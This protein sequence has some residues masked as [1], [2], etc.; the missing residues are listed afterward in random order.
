MIYSFIWGNPRIWDQ[1]TVY[2]ITFSNKGVTVQSK[3]Y[4]ENR[5]NVVNPLLRG[6]PYVKTT[7]PTN[8]QNQWNSGVNHY[9]TIAGYLKFSLDMSGESGNFQLFYQILK[10]WIFHTVES[11][12]WGIAIWK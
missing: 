2:E 7:S 8:H 9:R 6:P 11:W 3:A 1:K 10:K 12:E 4:A 5:A